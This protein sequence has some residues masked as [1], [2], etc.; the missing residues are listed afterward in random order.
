MVGSMSYDI[1]Q[2]VAENARLQAR[3]LEEARRERIERRRTKARRARQ[4][5]ARYGRAT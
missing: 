4:M 5:R 2:A 3:L 1:G